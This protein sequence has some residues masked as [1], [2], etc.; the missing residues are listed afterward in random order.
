MFVAALVP[1]DVEPRTCDALLRSHNNPT[2]GQPMRRSS[3]TVSRL[4]GYIIAENAG[5]GERAVRNDE[6]SGLILL[7]A[8]TALHSSQI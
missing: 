6:V 3:C 1:R 7:S 8:A 4:H 5:L 2:G